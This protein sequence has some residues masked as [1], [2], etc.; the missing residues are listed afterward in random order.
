M[1]R[2][3]SASVVAIR[4]AISI[5]LLGL[6]GLRSHSDFMNEAKTAQTDAEEKIQAA[7][8]RLLSLRSMENGDKNIT[9][10]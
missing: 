8:L 9:T 7:Q 10:I 5:F 6:M 3:T 2:P 4:V 1:A